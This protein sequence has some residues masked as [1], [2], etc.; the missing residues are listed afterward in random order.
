MTMFRI[1]TTTSDHRQSILK[2]EGAVRGD[3]VRAIQFGCQFEMASGRRVALD[4]SGVTFID[5][6]GVFLVRALADQGVQIRG[7]SP[8]I[9]ALLGLEDVSVGHSPTKET[10][11]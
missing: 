4:L 6:A 9:S 8:F 11:E 2:A 5:A 10:Q 3:A 1:T 7:G